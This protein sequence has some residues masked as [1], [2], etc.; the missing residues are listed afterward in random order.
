MADILF[1]CQRLPFPPNKGEKI[2]AYHILRHLSRSHRI[3]LACFIDTENDW[4]FA[5]SVR[6]FCAQVHFEPLSP[7]W[8][9]LR[10]V[11][12][13]LKDEP[14]S[15][16]YYWSARLYDWVKATSA[17]VGF[18]S[19]FVYSSVMAQFVAAC[20][21]PPSW[22]VLDYVDVDSDK[23]RQYAE[24][25]PWPLSWVY[26]REAS[27]L[28]EFDRYYARTSSACV[29]VSDSEVRLFSKL[30]PEVSSKTHAIENGVDVDFFSP[31]VVEPSCRRGRDRF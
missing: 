16:S 11:Q 30:A 19:V 14:L 1:L 15:S 31:N 22:L 8:A 21:S 4:A 23:W 26:R 5:D 24:T 3:H 18:Q 9:R 20:A 2:R 29:F 12:S 7:S 6:A 13:F 25:K 10:S 28:L 27:K 17:Q